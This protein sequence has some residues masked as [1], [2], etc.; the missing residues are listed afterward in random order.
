M[1]LWLSV[2]LAVLAVVLA[3]SVVAYLINKSN[4]I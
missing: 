4:E 2:V 1:P 3:V